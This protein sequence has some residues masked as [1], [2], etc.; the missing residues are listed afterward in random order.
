MDHSST[1]VPLSQLWFTLWPQYC[2]SNS[3]YSQPAKGKTKLCY[4][5]SQSD[6]YRHRKLDLAGSP[7]SRPD[8]RGWLP[9]LKTTIWTCFFNCNS[10]SIL[11][12]WKWGPVTR[13]VG[14]Q[15][16]I[17]F[18]REAICRSSAQ[19]Q[20]CYCHRAAAEDDEIVRLQ[21]LYWEP[22]RSKQKQRPLNAAVDGIVLKAFRLMLEWT[23]FI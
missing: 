15:V 22:L 21:P 9:V 13:E 19:A 5:H 14:D 1:R 4:H 12:I 17:G 11:S 16:L 23:A 10:G 2:W 18:Q 3:L 6:D 20:A 8:Q 7:C